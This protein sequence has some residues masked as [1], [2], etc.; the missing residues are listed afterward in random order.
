MGGLVA[1]RT[2]VSFVGGEELKPARPYALRGIVASGTASLAVPLIAPEEEVSAQVRKSIQTAFES[3][4]SPVRCLGTAL[5]KR[6]HSQCRSVAEA[7]FRTRPRGP[8]G[9]NRKKLGV[10]TS[11]C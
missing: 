10:G 8:S 1:H 7:C 3:E 6:D 11:G 4:D 2:I 5:N 9:L